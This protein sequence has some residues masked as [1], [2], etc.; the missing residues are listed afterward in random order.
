MQPAMVANILGKKDP[1]THS[2]KPRM[3]P[4]RRTN[5]WLSLQVGR[6]MLD[7]IS[8]AWGLSVL[9]WTKYLTVLSRQ[10]SA[11]HPP[12]RYILVYVQ[13]YQYDIVHRKAR[14]RGLR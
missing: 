4:P 1:R 9:W 12:P 5:G 3:M 11:E 13:R 2:G 8:Q 6:A 14:R 7:V 10:T